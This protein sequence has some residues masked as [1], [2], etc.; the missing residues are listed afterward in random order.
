MVWCLHKLVRH[1][2]R[3]VTAAALIASVIAA[4][5]VVPRPVFAFDEQEGPDSAG[6]ET[7]LL[8]TFQLHADGDGDGLTPDELD[9]DAVDAYEPLAPA[10][11]DIPDD[12]ILQIFADARSAQSEGDLDQAQELYERVIAARPRGQ[13][14]A[15]A[16][17][18]L[19][20]LYRRPAAR[21]SE[22]GSERTQSA[23]RKAD[24]SAQAA[25]APEARR[26]LVILERQF[27]ASVG[28]RVFFAKGAAQLGAR[29]RDVISAQAGWLKAHPDLVISVEGHAD[30]GQAPEDRQDAL[31][32][33]RAEAVRG[34]LIKAGIQSTRVSSLSHGRTAPVAT[35]R[36]PDCAAQNR[37][38]VTVISAG[39]I[40]T[41]GEAAGPASS[42]GDAQ[43]GRGQPSIGRSYIQR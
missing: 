36:T 33:A 28:D 29:A 34:E 26:R 17:S 3:A 39:P 43:Q 21:D 11:R 31:A 24:E 38:A 22:N 41:A 4:G 27:I 25:L 40:R 19:A 12:E 1:S 8:G 5:T 9:V 23:R 15:E 20:E 18:N 14:A 37:R 32:L 35:C 10:F 2:W 16:R 42:R 13:L 30:D 6:S 7:H